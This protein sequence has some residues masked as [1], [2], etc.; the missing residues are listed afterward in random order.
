MLV[1]T[2]E[3]E[4]RRRM[5]RAQR[6]KGVRQQIEPLDRCSRP[7]N[8]TT[9][10]VSRNSEP[11]AKTARRRSGT[12]Q[13]DAVRHNSNRHPKF[14]ARSA[15]ASCSDVACSIAA[16]RRFRPSSSA[17]AIAF[18]HRPRAHRFRL[19]HAARRDDIGNIGGAR[20]VRRPPFRHIP[21]AMDVADVGRSESTD[22]RGA[23]ACAEKSLRE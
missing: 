7:R 8:S 13:V 11:L 12:M 1:G 15:P 2:G 10:A 20:Q 16:P 22:E 5:C 21:D 17:K 9:N 3:H 6:G 14:S 4:M 19:E 23:H 18:R